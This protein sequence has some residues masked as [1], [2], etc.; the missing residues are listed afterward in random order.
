MTYRILTVCTGNICRS[1][2]A[3][4]LLREAVADAGL[5]DRIE[6]ESAGTT[7]WEAGSPIDP[8]AG[9]LLAGRG[10]DARGHRARQVSTEDLDAADLVLAL[11]HDHV[12]PLERLGTTRQRGLIHLVREFDPDAPEDLGIRDPWYGDMSDFEESA[13]LIDAAVPGILRFV[14]EE[15]ARGA[16]ELS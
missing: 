5:E 12:G 14:Q 6:V 8:R 10:I 15:I 9:Q 7:G 1:P 16:K 11:D 13:A 2:M 3:E 4:Y